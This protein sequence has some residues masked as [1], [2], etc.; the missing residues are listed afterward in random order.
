MKLYLVTIEDYDDF[1]VIAAFEEHH[2]DLARELARGLPSGNLHEIETQTSID[3]HRITK[4]LLPQE[5][6]P[7]EVK[8]AF[9]RYINYPRRPTS[10]FEGF[11]HPQLMLY[12][13]ESHD[14][15]KA[16]AEAKAARKVLLDAEAW[17]DP[18]SDPNYSKAHNQAFDLLNVAKAHLQPTG[19]KAQAPPH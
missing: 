6:E 19:Q 9:D 14:T 7:T 11:R 15:D 13:T 8:T 3:M 5:G 16:V 10:G 1:D 17:P 12:I 4:V 2:Q 18:D